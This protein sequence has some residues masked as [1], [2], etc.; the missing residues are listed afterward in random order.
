[1]IK[2]KSLLREESG[3]KK[4][5]SLT[6]AQKKALYEYMVTSGG[7]EPEEYND[8]VKTFLY[9]IQVV[10]PQ[11]IAAVF[12]KDGWDWTQG[13]RQNDEDRIKKIDLEIQKTK[14]KWPYIVN[15]ATSFQQWKTNEIYHGDGFHRTILALRKNEPIEFL[16]L[17]RVK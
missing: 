1:M 11:Q 9:R 15:S 8:Y 5:I 14:E 17:K 16:F 7:V 10:S 13:L 12:E 3:W 6:S 4:Y 2:L